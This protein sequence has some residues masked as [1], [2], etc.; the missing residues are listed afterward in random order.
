MCSSDL[1]EFQREINRGCEGIKPGWVRVNFNYFIDEAAFE[2]IVAAVDLIASEGIHLLPSYR[3]EPDTGL[4]HHERGDTGPALSLHE[5]SYA[6]GAMTFE[7]RRRTEEIDLTRHLED[8]RSLLAEARRH[9][10]GDAARVETT[11]DFEHLRW[12][13]Y[14]EDLG[15]G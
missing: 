2:Y 8:A 11:A 9:P 6:S 3:F 14:P 7:N 15:V 1:H 10:T 4:W 12:F 13:P 5:I